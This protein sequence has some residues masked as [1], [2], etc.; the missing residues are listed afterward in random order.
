VV[1]ASVFGPDVFDS[2]YFGLSGPIMGSC[3]QIR[4]VLVLIRT[5]LG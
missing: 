5:V 3:R 2:G 1:Q 4:D